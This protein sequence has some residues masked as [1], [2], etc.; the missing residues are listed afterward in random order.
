MHNQLITLLNSDVKTY[1]IRF[2]M[3]TL[4]SN[5]LVTKTGRGFWNSE[6]NFNMESIFAEI[7]LLIS[8]VN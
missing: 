7:I 3:D 2:R 6:D 5:W 4:V 8:I 1:Y